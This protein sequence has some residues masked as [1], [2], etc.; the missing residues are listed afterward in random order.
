MQDSTPELPH[1]KT[2]RDIDRHINPPSNKTKR[3]TGKKFDST[4][5]YP[6]EGPTTHTTCEAG[7]NCQI[8]GHYHQKQKPLSGAAKRKREASDKKPKPRSPPEYVLCEFHL[9]GE[10]GDPSHAHDQHQDLDNDATRAYHVEHCEQT[11]P[12]PP[13]HLTTHIAM[14]THG[15][16]TN[17]HI[18]DT[19]EQC[20]DTFGPAAGGAIHEDEPVAAAATTEINSNEYLEQSSEEASASNSDGDSDEEFVDVMGT[21]DASLFTVGAIGHLETSFFVLGWLMTVS[22]AV[23]FYV[24]T[25][26]TCIS[27]EMVSIGSTTPVVFGVDAIT[28]Y[29]RVGGRVHTSGVMQTFSETFG[30]QEND[31]IVAEHF[32][33]MYQLVRIAPV[34]TA[35]VKAVLIDKQL[36]K[37][38]IIDSSGKVG[39]VRTAVADT[40]LTHSHADA[41]LS[42]Q[43]VYGNTLNHIINQIILRGILESA[44]SPTTNKPHFRHAGRMQMS[45]CIDPSSA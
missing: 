6:G 44:A 8:A 19:L 26:L 41:W 39:D 28:S 24:L 21:H 45:Q 11:I 30:T 22:R 20:R 43:V 31:I 4:K 2:Q 38:R 36:A 12:L 14:P 40:L 42:D 13:I 5:G 18:R 10:C 9:T 37:R 34:F 23:V 27:Q 33:N 25:H 17:R 7:I 35:A 29:F 16:T 3:R 15:G 1:G 32:S